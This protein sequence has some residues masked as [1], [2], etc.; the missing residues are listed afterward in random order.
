MYLY[1]WYFPNSY[2]EFQTHSHIQ[3]VQSTYL[4]SSMAEANPNPFGTW[5]NTRRKNPT[6]KQDN[7]GK[8]PGSQ[9]PSNT[10]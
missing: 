8:D 10:F 6:K 7:G 1:L 9:K 5:E 3:D 4:G 2:F